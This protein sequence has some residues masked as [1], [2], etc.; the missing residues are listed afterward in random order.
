MTFEITSKG[1]PMVRDSYIYTYVA[2]T[3]FTLMKYWK[4]SVKMCSARIRT[5]IQIVSELDL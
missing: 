2:N 4:C 1:K 3:S 5:R